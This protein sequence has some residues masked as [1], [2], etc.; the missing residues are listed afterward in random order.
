MHGLL[1]E[2]FEF[3]N[4]ILS[5]YFGNDL[6]VGDTVQKTQ[7]VLEDHQSFPL[8]HGI[9]LH[10]LIKNYLSRITILQ[11]FLR[12]GPT[13]GRRHTDFRQISNAVAVR[14][15]VAVEPEEARG[16]CRRC[17]TLVNVEQQMTCRRLCSL[18]NYLRARFHVLRESADITYLAMYVL[19]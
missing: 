4:H 13:H 12:T 3:S 1:H 16:G 15:G 19:R 10:L 6:L 7:F 17:G 11:G 9:D 5:A 14:V 2:G 18:I 8:L